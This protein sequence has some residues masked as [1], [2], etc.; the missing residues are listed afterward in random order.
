MEVK[1]TFYLSLIP[2]WQKDEASPA[3]LQNIGDIVHLDSLEELPLIEVGATTGPL[4]VG[5]DTLKQLSGSKRKDAVQHLSGS[6][7]T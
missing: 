2:F 7:F 1:F 4:Y 6:F 3:S 5:T